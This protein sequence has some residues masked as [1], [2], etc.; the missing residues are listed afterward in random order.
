MSLVPGAF[1][2]NSL[3]N[4]NNKNQKLKSTKLDKRFK[5]KKLVLGHLKIFFFRSY[6]VVGFYVGGYS[7]LENLPYVASHRNK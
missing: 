3:I 7:P 1:T 5:I 6:D 2:S 4:V